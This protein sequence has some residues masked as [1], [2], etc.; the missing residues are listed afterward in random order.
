MN[1]T[2]LDYLFVSLVAVISVFIIVE[3]IS[4]KKIPNIIIIRGFGVGLLLYVAGLVGG[5]ITFPYF[6][7]VLINACISLAVGYLFWIVRFW[8][9]GD[10]KLFTVFAFLLPLQFYWKSYVPYFPSITLLANIFICAYAV[11]IMRSFV[12]LGVLLYQGDPF[13]TK[14][15]PKVKEFFVTGQYRNLWT[16]T[17][18][19]V[20]GTVVL[21][22]A[23]MLLIIRYVFNFRESWSFGLVETS[24]AGMSVWMFVAAIVRKYI[25]DREVDL[26]GLDEI[27]VGSTPLIQPK[28]TELFP[29]EFLKK[30]GSVKAEGLD[31]EQATMLR[32]M[33]AS[34]GIE[35]LHM[36]RNMPF[37]PWIIIG[38]LV[39]IL[40]NVNIMQF[41]GEALSRGH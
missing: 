40:L 27:Q 18:V 32:A 33:L 20:I 14:F 35:S 2:I 17:N 13:F 8:P 12:H 26:Q 9:A 7:D 23:V 11:L 5:L 39:T 41:V 34:K 10:A 30:L 6:G 15:F 1:L 21:R 29:K 19:A 28:D 25:A 36:H 38:L 22:L 3:D 24:L 31:E 37:S 4:R 16:R